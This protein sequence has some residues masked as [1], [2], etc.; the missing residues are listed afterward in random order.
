MFSRHTLPSTYSS[1]VACPVGM[2]TTSAACPSPP[3]SLFNPTPFHSLSPCSTS[4]RNLPAHGLVLL[5]TWPWF[6]I[7]PSPTQSPLRTESQPPDVDLYQLQPSLS[8]APPP[9]FL[10]LSI[11]LVST[12]DCWFWGHGGVRPRRCR[13]W[14]GLGCPA[15]SRALSA[16]DAP[17]P[18][19]RLPLKPLLPAGLLTPNL[20]SHR[21]VRSWTT[22]TTPAPGTSEHPS[23]STLTEAPCCRHDHDAIAIR[24]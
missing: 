4:V 17:V 18:H 1:T 6:C 5:P 16:P 9:C 22:R 10:S 11:V 12:C 7:L 13:T 15:L 14:R 3:W 24:R 23:F 2:G 19:C 21:P 8:N 20:F